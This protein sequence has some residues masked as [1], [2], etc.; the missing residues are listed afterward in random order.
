[1]N[2]DPLRPYSVLWGGARP[3]EF[4]EINMAV[5]ARYNPLQDTV[6]DFFRGFFLRPLRFEGS[7]DP[8]PFRV[9]I[10][11]R[12]DAYVLRAEL[13]GVRKEDISVSVDGDTVAISAELRPER[14]GKGDGR[15][16]RA[17]RCY[18]KLCRTFALDQ[19][20]DGDGAQA[21]YA[22]GVLEL[23]LPK[24]VA[25]QARRVTIQ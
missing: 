10:T 22:D 21:R 19:A 25:A 7:G 11:E 12:D 14:E 24:K 17:E 2:P 1:L 8:V 20:V 9:E 16:L 4:K 18:G 23:T 3:I 6:D 5:L 15:V 13:A